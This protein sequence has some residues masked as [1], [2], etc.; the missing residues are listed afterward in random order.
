MFEAC[1]RRWP[2]MPMAPDMGEG[3]ASAENSLSWMQDVIGWLLEGDPAI[4]WQ[5][6]EDLVDAAP[7]EVAAERARVALDGWGARPLAAQ[8]DAGTWAQGLHLPKWTSTTYTLLLLLRWLGLPARDPQARSPKRNSPA[9]PSLHNGIWIFSADLSTSG[10][11][12]HRPIPASET[13]SKRYAQHGARTAGG[14]A[15]S[16]TPA[17]SGSRLKRP[18]RAALPPCG[19]FA[20]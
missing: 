3:M 9:S 19:A 6:V 1:A 7:D 17:G 4:R 14:G 2:K 20:C 12:G 13:A 10:Q 16:R 15:I 18:A 11:E 5:V 8:D